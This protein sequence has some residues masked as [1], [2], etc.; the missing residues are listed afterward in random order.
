MSD[1]ATSAGQQVPAQV[2]RQVCDSVIDNLGERSLRLLF[3]QSGLQQYY[4]GG[5]LPPD[6]DTPSLT[7][8]EL[9]HLFAT[10]FRI[11]GERG[12]RPILLRAG[13]TSLKHFRETNKTLAALAGAAFKVL[14]TDAKIKLVLARS[15]KIAEEL[16]HAPHRTYDTDAGFFVEISACPYCAG[17]KADQPICFFPLGFYGEAIRWATGATYAVEEV[18]C[19]AQGG[20]HCLI[21]IGRQPEAV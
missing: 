8:A 10:A 13:R 3:A 11:F 12:M 18:E 9:S 14:T 21:R 2:L 15:V 6:D 19:I 17:S 20:K 4:N 7:I 1:Q 5:A 16:L